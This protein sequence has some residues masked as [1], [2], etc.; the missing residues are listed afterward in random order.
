MQKSRSR[1]SDGVRIIGGE[2]RGRRIPVVTGTS[3]R[4]TPDRVRETVFNWLAAIVPGA[5]CLD[6]FAGTGVLGLEALSRGAGEALLVERDPAL[7]RSLEA[8]IERLGANARVIAADA[9]T[10]LATPPRSPFDIVFVDPPYE[11][12]PTEL[13]L[14][15]REWLAPEHRIYVER[16]MTSGEDALD[17]LAAAMPGARLLKRARA[18]GVA[19]GLLMFEE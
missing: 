12:D 13:L 6:L 16:P 19:Y 4:P 5:R 17:G 1:G 11:V 2:W 7:A 18:G 15:L 8:Q 3:V 9:T 10:V 14:S